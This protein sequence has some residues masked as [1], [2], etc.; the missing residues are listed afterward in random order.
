MTTALMKEKEN[1]KMSLLYKIIKFYF[2]LRQSTFRYVNADGKKVKIEEIIKTQQ[3]NEI[4]K[5][6]TIISRSE[7]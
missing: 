2:S 5:I 7:F 3:E 4:F 1:K 6:I